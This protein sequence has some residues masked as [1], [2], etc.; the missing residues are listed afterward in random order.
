MKKRVLLFLFISSL[1]SIHSFGQQ[2]ELIISGK[3]ENTPF[4]L[5]VKDIESQLPVEFMYHPQMADSVFIT[6]IFNNE[7][8]NKGLNRV[9]KELNFNFFINE[10]KQ[11]IITQNYKIRAD[12]PIN[13]FD[14]SG[15]ELNETEVQVIDF[16]EKEEKKIKLQ[17]TLENTVIEIGNKSN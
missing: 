3:Y 17:N 2:S 15:E 13:F 6:A 12:L 8:L 10:Q 16:L 14:R 5:F 9:F 7:K 11:I 4:D 1:T